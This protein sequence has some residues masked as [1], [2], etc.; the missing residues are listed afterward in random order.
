M[1]QIAQIPPTPGVIVQ[2]CYRLLTTNA[3][4]DAR[5]HPQTR[6]TIAD[7]TGVARCRLSP[8]C[9]GIERTSGRRA[10]FVNL[11]G[12]V[13]GKS[14]GTLHINV[15]RAA[16]VNK[17]DQP[18]WHLL[19]RSWV[20]ANALHAFERLIGLLDRLEHREIRSLAHRLFASQAVAEPFLCVPGSRSHH[21]A[22]DGGLLIHSVECAE[23][24]EALAPHVLEHHERDL[25]V[26]GAL[27]HDV[28]KIRILN[29]SKNGQRAIYGVTQE[30]LNLEVLA[31]FMQRLDRAWPEAGAGLREILAPARSYG[32]SGNGSPLLL[33]DFVRYVD[34]LSAGADIR[35]QSFRAV[36]DWRRCTRTEQGD[37]LKRILP[38]ASCPKRPAM[39][40]SS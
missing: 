7:P 30:A 20:P 3:A 32:G 15:S 26:M 28:A 31:P 22:M 40:V 29:G 17:L 5:G 19:P 2:G 23:M 24:A 6:F 36:P 18:S 10:R 1:T 25:A 14:D 9:F 21:H 12:R 11:S 27:L 38:L 34:R 13:A 35:W 16:A 39:E 37:L 8:D 4:T 33:T